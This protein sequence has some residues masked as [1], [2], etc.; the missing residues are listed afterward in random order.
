MK[1]RSTPDH[2]KTALRAT[3]ILVPVFGIHYMFFVTQATMVDSCDLILQSLF[4][5][6]I[7]ADSLQGAI[8]AMIFCLFNSEVS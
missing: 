7:A 8:V 3:L 1:L 2:L 6:A 4:Y 5:I